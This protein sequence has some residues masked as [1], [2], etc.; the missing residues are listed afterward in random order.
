MTDQE[1]Q[2]LFRRFATPVF[3]AANIP[4][5]KIAAHQLAEILWMAL[6]TGPEIEE[7]VFK[8]IGE[9]IGVDVQLIKDRYYQ[10]MK[11]AITEEEVQTLKARYK[12]Q[13]INNPQC[14]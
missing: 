10:E 14:P 13:K 2:N 9:I 5:R 12:V 6:V 11:P 3:R 1:A 4:K 8:K 7:L